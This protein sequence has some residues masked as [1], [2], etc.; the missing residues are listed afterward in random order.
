MKKFDV[1]E[2]CG[3]AW[4]IFSQNW[5]MLVAVFIVI[6]II[7]SICTSLFGTSATPVNTAYLQSMSPEEQLQYY[8][9]NVSVN[10]GQFIGELVSAVL[11]FGFTI[12][13]LGMVKGRVSDFS[14]DFWKQDFM[15]YVHFVVCHIA[16]GIIIAVGICCCIIPG[17]WLASR[18][19]FADTAIANNPKLTFIDAIKHSWAITDGYSLNIILLY[20]TFMVIAIAGLICCCVGI[21]PAAIVISLAECVA[22]VTLF[23]EPEE[24]EG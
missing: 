21:I 24:V 4:Q 11:S 7:Q 1:S 19:A 12:M 20:I 15:S 3:R 10:P 23:D 16:V 9:D 8:I 2:I 22:Y 17:I 14:I 13:M 6:M 5:L 18:L